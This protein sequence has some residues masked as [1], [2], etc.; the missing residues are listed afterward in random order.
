M[1]K[2]LRAFTTFFVQNTESAKLLSTIGLNNS[3]VTGDTRCD[4]VND[5]ASDKSLKDAVV[6]AF[7]GDG[8]VFVA[9]STWEEDERII[10]DSYKDVTG[11]KLVVVPH[12]TDEGRITFVEHAF[13]DFSI[14]K[15]SDCENNIGD[16][17][18]AE[19]CRNAEV[20]LVDKVGLLSKIYRY[21]R[22]AYV[23]GGFHVGIHNVLEPA[24]YGCPVI[25]GPKYHKFQE[26]KDLLAAGAATA[27][28]DESGFSVSVALWVSDPSVYKTAS[29]A[30]RSYVES[31]L[32]A[33]DTIIDK[34]FGQNI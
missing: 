14:I 31:N 12:E 4:R 8:E 28:H 16:E 26:A 18:V 29:N 11:I 7:K 24:A 17:K 10:A 13:K 21:A 22:F 32:G 25:F 1:R 30:A 23:G 2:A 33:S 27:V 3:Y 19:A 34:I 6:E 5:V 20:L 15:Y 9:G